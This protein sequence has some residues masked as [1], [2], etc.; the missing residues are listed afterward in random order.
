MNEILSQD[1]VD[2]L[3][4]SIST[5]EGVDEEALPSTEQRKVKILD[6][7]R[8]EKL[9]KEDIRTIHE[10]HNTFAKRASDSL[11]LRAWSYLRVASVDSLTYQEFIRS[12]PRICNNHVVR[13]NPFPVSVH[14]ALDPQLACALSARLLGSGPLEV[15]RISRA[16]SGI[17]RAVVDPI[18]I[19]LLEKEAGFAL[20]D[21]KADPP[22]LV[23]PAFE[24][25][26][27]NSAE[28]SV[29]GLSDMVTLVTMEMKIDE[30]E[31]QLNVA[32]PENFWELYLACCREGNP[33]RSA[34]A[35][36]TIVRTHHVFTAGTM[37]L[38]AKGAA[39]HLNL[40]PG[41]PG[42]RR[43]SMEKIDG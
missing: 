1:V 40:D 13:M 4:N 6:A 29:C 10:I 19:E 7:R 43:F 37:R 34:P 11:H 24:R 39:I 17:E 9:S 20:S 8:P 41:A 3:L 23:S 5:D 21:A 12:V 14:W 26:E 25:Y 28:V 22:L 27:A 35:D 33:S 2:A 32:Y 31:G 18:L 16:M 30:T 42:Q 36:D 15:V 38:Q